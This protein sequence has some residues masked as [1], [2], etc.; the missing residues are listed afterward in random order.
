LTAGSAAATLR[1]VRITSLLLAALIAAGAIVWMLGSGRGRDTGRSA[2][3]AEVHGANGDAVE[4]LRRIEA[5]L[6]DL[7]SRIEALESASSPSKDAGG[8]LTVPTHEI[9][10]RLEVLEARIVLLHRTFDDQLAKAAI[11]IESLE[12]RAAGAALLKEADRERIRRELEEEQRLAYERHAREMHLANREARARWIGEVAAEMG[13][14][15][16]D[17]ERIVRIY[18]TQSMRWSEIFQRIQG[19][20]AAGTRAS[21]ELR[22]LRQETDGKLRE[23]LTEEQVVRFRELEG[24]RF[25][26]VIE[27]K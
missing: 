18:E 22:A 9:L 14:S 7:A 4:R 10:D 3:P 13:L 1:P 16:S 23:F 20:A 17:R 19:P 24:S 15:E 25:P 12:R 11:S 8:S 2:V 5:R 27:I 6:S 26:P 21:G